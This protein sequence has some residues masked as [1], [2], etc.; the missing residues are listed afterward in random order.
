MFVLAVLGSKGPSRPEEGPRRLGH[1]LL[2]PSLAGP[3]PPAEAYERHNV[4]V[5]FMETAWKERVAPKDW[6]MLEVRRSAA[7]AMQHSFMQDCH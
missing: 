2:P 7:P 6:L 3:P 4:R 1:A 5:Q